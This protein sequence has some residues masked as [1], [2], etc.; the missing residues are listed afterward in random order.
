V[1]LVLWLKEIDNEDVN[2]FI[3]VLII[4]TRNVQNV[5]YNIQLI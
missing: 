5:F 1:Y 3:D 2:K 4:Y